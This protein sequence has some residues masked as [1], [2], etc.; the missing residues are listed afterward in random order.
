MVLP[1]FD[2]DVP[3]D[4]VVEVIDVSLLSAGQDRYQFRPFFGADGSENELVVQGTCAGE[5]FEE[6]NEM[7]ALALAAQNTGSS[8]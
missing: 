7:E 8:L 4:L 2:V 6:I 1:S 5:F 3:K